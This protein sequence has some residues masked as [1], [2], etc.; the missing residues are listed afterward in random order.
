V[1]KK[2]TRALAAEI[3]AERAAQ[4]MTQKQLADASGINYQT[5][6]KHV[7]KGDRD[8]SIGQ[9]VALSEAFGIEPADLIN[10]TMA[11]AARMDD[12]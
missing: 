11:R 10:K 9:I 8:I 5:L 4:R 1:D 2:H 12:E 6:A 7:L 3:E